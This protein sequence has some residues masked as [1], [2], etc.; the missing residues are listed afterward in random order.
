MRDEVENELR[1]LERNGIIEQ[2]NETKFNSPLMVIRKP[3][4]GLRLANIFV[5]LNEK[6]VKESM[7]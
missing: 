6:T 3:T 1:R 4:G 7:T 5:K 2:D